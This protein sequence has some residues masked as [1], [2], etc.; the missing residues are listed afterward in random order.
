M[1]IPN[2]PEINHAGAIG[3]VHHINE[4][5]EEE[6]PKAKTLNEETIAAAVTATTNLDE[7]EAPEPVVESEP[8]K[9][10]TGPTETK[11]EPEETTTEP[12]ETKTAEPVVEPKSAAAATEEPVEEEAVEP[13]P[14]N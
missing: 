14:A 1:N 6:P 2:I 5:K 13:E 3:A 11:T 8:A 4:T 10:P 7:K 12:E 9:L